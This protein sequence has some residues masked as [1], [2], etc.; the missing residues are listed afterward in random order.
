MNEFADPLRYDVPLPL[1]TY[2][3]PLG[4]P[5]RV[6]TN[7]PDIITAVETLWG[8]FDQMF[9]R[10]VIDLR[11]AVSPGTSVRPGPVPFPSGQ[12]HLITVVHSAADFAVTDVDRGF[13]FG[14]L[15]AGIAKDHAYSSYH[16]LEPLVYLTLSCLYLTPVHAACVGFGGRGVLL[17]GDSGAG[18]TSLAY[19][20]ARRGWTYVA[21]DAVYLLRGTSQLR[22]IGK[23]QQIRF[24]SSA[25]Q[26]F[27]ELAGYREVVRPNGKP[28]LE[29]STAALGLQS[30]EHEI[31]PQLLVFLQR[32][33]GAAARVSPVSQSRALASLEQVICYGPPEVRQQQRQT[34][35]SL[36]RIP[37]VEMIYSD[38]SDVDPLLR[39]FM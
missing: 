25:K 35:E 1:R 9:G 22:A 27:P 38:A 17:C 33:P 18:K 6:T 7:S 28:D 26:L 2:V 19:A 3:Y 21:D 8:Q 16:F 12:G 14:W 37:A 31:E 36:V 15:T 34:L 32:V 39:K 30:L 4:F 29:L 13:I 23:P 24:R 5:L 10:N 20:L 11:L